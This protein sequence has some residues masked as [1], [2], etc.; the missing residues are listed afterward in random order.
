MVVER[1]R[2]SVDVLAFLNS[3]W[4]FLKVRKYGPCSE[5]GKL[6]WVLD[7]AMVVDLFTFLCLLLLLWSFVR[8]SS[9][10]RELKSQDNE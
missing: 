2:A 9:S 3:G 5:G 4:K 7:F 10:V 6:R 1:I 8:L